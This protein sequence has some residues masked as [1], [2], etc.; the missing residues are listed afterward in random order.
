MNTEAIRQHT[1]ERWLGSIFR[2]ELEPLAL[3]VYDFSDPHNVQRHLPLKN[4]M[5]IA[6]YL[7][8]F[9]PAD[10][11]A[12]VSCPILVILAVAPGTDVDD[13]LLRRAAET[14]KLARNL[15]YVCMRDTAHDIPWHRPD[16]LAAAIREFLVAQG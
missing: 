14:A 10:Y 15:K 13:Q 1:R 8:E 5:Q 7:W 2:P 4:H 16:A 11:F 12:R 6:R 3:S 9:Q